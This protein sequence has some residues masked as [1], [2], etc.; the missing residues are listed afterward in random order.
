MRLGRVLKYLRQYAKFYTLIMVTFGILLMT[1][2][3]GCVFI[4][5]IN[6]CGQY[7]Y[8]PYTKYETSTDGVCAQKNAFKVWA[9][10]LHYGVTMVMG[11]SPRALDGMWDSEEIDGMEFLHNVSSDMFSYVAMI[12]GL[13]MCAKFF[14]EVA[15]IA[16]HGDRYG[17]DFRVRLNRIL[18]VMSQNG[19]PDRLQ[20]RV[21]KYYDYLWL[22][23]LHGMYLSV[24]CLS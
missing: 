20:H 17:W 18:E 13:F 12:I 5:C 24:F 8:D 4:A 10:G 1:H 3:F 22:N 16:H 19:V 7:D 9:R 23:N 21:K 2:M 11:G 6:P 15:V 14:G